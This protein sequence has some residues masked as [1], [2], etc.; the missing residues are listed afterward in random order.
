MSNDNVRFDR[1]ADDADW[2]AAAADAF[3]HWR[4]T[5]DMKE[6]SRAAVILNGAAK[7]M[8]VD[9]ERTELAFR[10]AETLLQV[11]IRQA[12]PDILDYAI[13]ILERET[14]FIHFELDPR[15]VALLAI[16]HASLLTERFYLSG[17]IEDLA[18]AMDMYEANASFIENF[19]DSF[20]E[21]DRAWFW[22]GFGKAHLRKGDVAGQ[23]L[24]LVAAVSCLG[25]AA[26]VLSA[27]SAFGRQIRGDLA[28]AQMDLIEVKDKV[29]GLN[30][31][32]EFQASLDTA[33]DTLRGLTKSDLM[34]GDPHYLLQNLANLL[35]RRSKVRP[36]GNPDRIVD[37]RE[38]LAVCEEGLKARTPSE[39]E[40]VML[41]GTRA[42]CHRLLAEN[43]IDAALE[44]AYVA[45]VESARRTEHP[46]MLSIAFNWQLLLSDAGRWHD[47]ASVGD[48]ALSLLEKLARNQPRQDYKQVYLGH[49]IGLAEATAAARARTGDAEGAMTSLERTLA[50]VW[51]ER[52]FGPRSLANRLRAAGAPDL[53]R[54]Y[55]DLIA[56]ARSIDAPD[57]ELRKAE[58]QL[59][60]LQTSMDM[61]LGSS[62]LRHA[63]VIAPKDV[64]K[65]PSMHLITSK[66]GSLVLL[67]D[68]EGHVT[69]IDLP[70][71]PAAEVYAMSARFRKDVVSSNAAVDSVCSTAAEIVASLEHA[72]LRPIEAQILELLAGHREGSASKIE[73]CQALRTLAVVTAGP[74][75]G[76]PL[77]AARLSDGRPCAAVGFAYTPTMAALDDPA[78]HLD[79]S[80][81]VLIVADLAHKGQPQLRGAVQELENLSKIW[82][83]AHVLPGPS[84]TRSAVL[85]ALPTASLIHLACH[86]MSD[87][88]DPLN[89]LVV[90]A[91][92][93]VTMG[94]VLSI[95]L[96]P[97]CLVVLSACQTAV[98][99]PSVPNEA[100]SLAMGFLAAGAATVVASLWPVPDTSTAALMVAFHEALRGGRRPAHALGAAQSAMAAGQ[101]ADPSRAA[102]WRNP[103]Y[104]A[105]FV[106]TGR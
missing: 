2:I 30:P 50:V 60:Q 28:V 15:S 10:I 102:D 20:E 99:D 100:M 104:W 16:C 33:I 6:L 95:Q 56:R 96:R 13:G 36:Q 47:A 62:D 48:I 68:E 8:T 91:D 106:A 12:R 17:R 14:G 25:K 43:H 80:A 103:F 52:Y 78:A 64:A 23:R 40:N 31:T 87:D 42:E 76:L 27:E 21:H 53:A 5:R 19:P 101:L 105:G 97:G 94:D 83:H 35:V 44:S 24:E 65:V 22:W 82:P 34:S 88:R 81:S 70:L 4:T 84:A 66:V 54:Q 41:L 72:V 49:G 79:L 63:E 18:A 69:A 61:V 93:D 77:H 11:S 39:W 7:R 58:A 98:R 67:G 32:P 55:L 51:R 26:K 89:S 92:G 73:L 86:G 71:A 75:S 9:P 59:A 38:A 37:L 46:E 74:F 85:T 3:E 45:A 57:P 90:L 1:P 29:A